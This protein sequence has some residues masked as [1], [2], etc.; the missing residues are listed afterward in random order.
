MRAE[1]RSH[2]IETGAKGS[3]DEQDKLNQMCAG[4][5]YAERGQRETIAKRR[6]AGAP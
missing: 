4:G 6:D 1:R 5:L 3:P 2:L